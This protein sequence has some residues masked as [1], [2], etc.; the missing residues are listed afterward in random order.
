M[1]ALSLR[2][3]QSIHYNARLDAQREGMSLI[4]LAMSCRDRTSE[5]RMK[6]A[7]DRRTTCVR[8]HQILKSTQRPNALCSTRL[9]GFK[10]TNRKAP[11]TDYDYESQLKGEINPVG[12]IRFHPIESRNFWVTWVANLQACYLHS[13]RRGSSFGDSGVRMFKT[14]RLTHG[15]TDLW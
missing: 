10:L 6:L 13:L 3:P 2:L 11:A 12:D 9:E 4:P 14:R 5:F 15:K 7:S 8:S 1:S